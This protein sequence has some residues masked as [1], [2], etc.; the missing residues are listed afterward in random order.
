M[1]NK[2]L[3]TFATCPSPN[4]RQPSPEMGCSPYLEFSRSRSG[5]SASFSQVWSEEAVELPE[6]SR[7]EVVAE[8]EVEE[9]ARKRQTMK[10][11][12]E[13]WRGRR[14]PL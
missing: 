6:E 9:E 10:R 1:A 13:S 4:N 2:K 8:L 14:W 7:E 5:L 3:G 12:G 11:R